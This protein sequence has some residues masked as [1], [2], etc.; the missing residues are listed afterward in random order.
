MNT[1]LL[2]KLKEFD[3]VLRGYIKGCEQCSKD[4]PNL[5]N[6]IIH[7]VHKAAPNSKPHEEV[8]HGH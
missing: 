2:D 5:W 3:S 4:M 8:R 7:D 1:D 6:E